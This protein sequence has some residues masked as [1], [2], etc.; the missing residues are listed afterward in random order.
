M[1]IDLRQGETKNGLE[2][3]YVGESGANGGG[4]FFTWHPTLT[5]TI[6]SIEE[7]TID[8][9]KRL[10]VKAVERAVRRAWQKLE[11]K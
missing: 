7:D 3:G 5:Q 4:Y 1:F 8:R 10:G 6:A 2:F 11:G 9:P